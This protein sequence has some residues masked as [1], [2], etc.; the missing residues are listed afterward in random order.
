MRVRYRRAV[1]SRF[2][3]SAAGPQATLLHRSLM[4]WPWTMPRRPLSTTLID[5]LQSRQVKHRRTPCGG[6]SPDALARCDCDN[7]PPPLLPRVW[8]GM[9]KGCAGSVERSDPQKSH[10]PLRLCLRGCKL[11]KSKE[12]RITCI[13]DI[14]N[15]V[16][17]ER[18]RYPHCQRPSHS[19]AQR[20][21]RG[22]TRHICKR[23]KEPF[24]AIHHKPKHAKQPGEPRQP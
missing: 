6:V 4:C 17:V 16:E 5:Y 18:Y 22:E 1:S 20:Y 14:W 2:A 13:P 24:L 9:E 7:P 23:G 8:R 15:S 21:L 19:D 11:G 12:M 3:V 10:K